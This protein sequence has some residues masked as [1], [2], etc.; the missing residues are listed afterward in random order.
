[1]LKT[2]KDVTFVFL[3][4]LFTG[5][6]TFFAG[7]WS[8]NILTP[9]E[10]GLWLSLSLIM[11]YGNFIQ[12]GVINGMHREIPRLLGRDDDES[13]QSIREITFTWLVITTVIV[14]L[15]SLGILWLDISPSLKILIVLACI[16]VPIQQLLI[17]E[18][19]LYATISNFRKVASIQL[20]FGPGQSIFTIIFVYFWGIY[21]MF[22]AIIL[23]NL[24]GMIY[25]HFSFN[26]K[27]NL[28][29]NTSI[30]LKLGKIG[31]PLMLI[32]FTYILLIS[33]DRLF[34]TFFLDHSALGM[35]SLALLIYQTIIMLPAII[36]QVLYPKLNFKYGKIK[37]PTEINLLIEETSK[38]IAIGM[39]LILGPVYIALPWFVKL[40][41][42]GYTNGIHAANLLLF[43]IYFLSIA[44]MFTT[45]LK[46]IDKQ[47]TYLYILLGTVAL[48]CGF[49]YF[50]IIF[51]YH[52]EGI[53]FATSLTYFFYSVVIYIVSYY[54][55]GRVIPFKK[56]TSYYVPYFI[57]IA[58]LYIS[59]LIGQ[60][61]PIS[62]FIFLIIYFLVVI[63]LFKRYIL[64]AFGKYN[65]MG[66]KK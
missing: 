8:R 21:G 14:I 50:V 42:P 28:R 63:L 48:N 20:I 58:A 54:Y 2:I 57:M 44:G 53:A 15:L 1:M 18:R 4:T 35:Y 66:L 60:N 34:I 22:H 19:I 7:I 45:Y 11:L 29:F 16:S 52:I 25:G 6:L 3:P 26:Q 62:L 5:I 31:F 55:M 65:I 24:L 61:T 17:Y 43:G 36:E 47:V 39:P 40:M 46:I 32:A 49:N 30:I 12:F 38:L 51:N 10:F 9:E 64:S 37:N 41:L 27:I 59:L 23:A 13:A 33:F 56:I